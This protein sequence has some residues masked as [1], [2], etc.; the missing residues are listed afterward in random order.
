MWV[1]EQ[2][3][4]KKGREEKLASVSVDVHGPVIL[5]SH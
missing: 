2:S 4:N 5:R 3:N 1:Y